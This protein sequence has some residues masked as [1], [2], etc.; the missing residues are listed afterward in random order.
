MQAILDSLLAIVGRELA[1]PHVAMALYGFTGVVT[2]LGIIVWL[3]DESRDSPPKLVAFLLSP[4]LLLLL[5][6]IVILVVA[7]PYIGLIILVQSLW[8]ASEELLEA[9]S[10]GFHWGLIALSAVVAFSV[11]Q[12]LLDENADRRTRALLASSEEIVR[13]LGRIASKISADS[14]K[15]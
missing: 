4:L 13:Q 1:R 10:W 7:W 8:T 5:V 12:S 11:V 9:I 15:E 2:S 3:L 14:G 6:P